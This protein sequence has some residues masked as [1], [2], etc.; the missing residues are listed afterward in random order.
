MHW[1]PRL[2]RLAATLTLLALILA[3]LSLNDG[4]IPA[5]QAQTTIDYDSD[6][7]RLIE[8]TTLAQLNAIRWDLNGDGTVDDTTNQSTYTAAFPAAA[9]GMGCPDSAADADA[10]PDP[11]L[12]YELR[13]DITFDQNGDGSV[14]AADS[15]GLYWNEGAG[16]TPIGNLANPYTGEFQ[17]RGHTISH[18]FINNAVADAPGLFGVIGKTGSVT[19]LGLEQVNITTT[20]PSAAGSLAGV[21]QGTVTS[22]YATGTVAG[23]AVAG[24]LVGL[25][26]LGTV[27]AS[28]SQAA[29]SLVLGDAAAGGLVGHNLL[30]DIKASYAAGP[31]SANAIKSQAGGL[32]GI[33][34]GSITASYARGAV[35]ATGQGSRKGGLAAYDL[36][37][38]T[39]SYW[40]TQTTGIAGSGGLGQPTSHLQAPTGYTGLYA[41]WNLNLDGVEGGD[42]PWHFGGNL[43]YPILV[44]GDIKSSPQQRDYDSDNNQRIEITT[45]EQLNAIRWDLNTDGV[46][47]AADQANYNAAFPGAIAGMGCAQGDTAATCTGYELKADLDFDTN[48]DGEFDET[49]GAHHN[50]G[51]GWFSIGS[52]TTSFT[53]QFYGGGKTIANL[54]VNQNET[55]QAGL[56]GEVGS[57]GI[58]DGVKLRDVD[59]SSLDG[60]AVG[61]LA[62]VSAGTIKG[63][64]A[65][66]R[67]RADETVGTVY[68]G[69]LVGSNTNRITSSYAKVDL[70]GSA[71][72]AGGLAGHNGSTGRIIASY[73]D[74]APIITS[75]NNAYLG[76]LVGHN[77]G[78]ITAAYSHSPVK[79]T[80]STAAAGG[81]VGYNQRTDS[82][83]TTQ[84]TIT[85]SYAI[86]PVV[87]AGTTPSVGGLVGKN[88]GGVATNSYWDTPVS[89]QSS[90]ALGTGKTRAE[91]TDPTG[92]T[93]I[94]ANWNLN[95]DTT[96]G[97]DDPWDFQ[98]HYP[99][100]KYGGLSL[101]NQAY[102]YPIYTNHIPVLYPVVGEAVLYHLNDGY[103]N[104]HHGGGPIKWEVSADGVT[105]WTQVSVRGQDLRS[106]GNSYTFVPKA[107]EANYRLRNQVNTLESGWI[108]SY[109][110]PPIKASWTGATAAASFASGHNPPR[111][112]QQ[113][114]V[115]GSDQMRWMLCKAATTSD[116]IV[117]SPSKAKFISYTPTTRDQGKYVYAYRYYTDSS[118][119][120]TKA[121]TPFIGPILAAASSSP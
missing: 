99:K 46:V 98:N 56:F 45:L 4:L 66:G 82:T 29:V 95:L 19:G 18:L 3:A 85:A 60:T 68:A 77:Q 41:N 84:G 53:G 63:S 73:S 72:A 81:L 71:S 118:G 33:N 103:R 48:G 89:G 102:M 55:T 83:S 44:Y 109:I 10:D 43:H 113:I 5:A 94:Y 80:G 23:S 93:G 62:G 76:G 61:A 117:H 49:D 32:A 25:N 87:A 114:T 105:G 108:Y 37:T 15:A 7:D 100:L 17:G 30:G 12:G 42:N 79:S 28:F 121:S 47:A 2:P 11:C 57:S 75:R 51:R 91:L 59:I 20:H 119:M 97:N 1:T 13:A 21:N 67:V 26:L 111:V 58:I 9:A 31:V 92:Y 27:Q 16:W 50:S 78:A 104:R 116:C 36:G 74:F 14:T 38:E 34:Q 65:T 70:G 115:S 112:G 101:L 40:D 35:S 64:F 8:L 24:G 96:A 52:A 120:L 88:S 22:S 54:Y 6:D 107:S 110:T 106:T 86:G 39:D 90:S 69:G